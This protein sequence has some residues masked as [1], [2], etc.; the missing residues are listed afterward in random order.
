MEYTVTFRV[1]YA[2][3]PWRY[4]FSRSK[5]RAL[6]YRTETAEAMQAWPV[7]EIAADD[8]LCFLWVTWPKLVQ[9]LELLEAW[10]FQ[11]ITNAFVWRK[12]TRHGKEQFGSGYYTRGNTEPCLVGKRGKGVPILGRSVRQLIN[13]P[14]QSHSR[15]PDEAVRRI[16]ELVGTRVPKVELFARRWSTN[17]ATGPRGWTQTG[18]EF[19][20][21]LITEFIAKCERQRTAHDPKWDDVA[22]AAVQLARHD[23]AM[24]Y[25]RPDLSGAPLAGDVH[26]APPL[27]RIDL[28][29]QCEQL[30]GLRHDPL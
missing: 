30:E 19:D 12:L 2:D 13:A 4:S 10:G 28:A 26:P 29:R 21:H 5:S 23:D 14:V 24:S 17:A 22:E 20:G 8:S 7:S 6:D 27:Y 16:T 25:K 11:Y 3:P 1:I 9:G 18:L 15:K